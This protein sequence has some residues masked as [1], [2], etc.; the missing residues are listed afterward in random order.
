[1]PNGGL[2]LRG[3]I[4]HLMQCLGDVLTGQ[5]IDKK[6]RDTWLDL[7]SEPTGGR[8]HNDWSPFP[9]PQRDLQRDIG[10]GFVSGRDHHYFRPSPLAQ[11]TG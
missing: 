4:E 3:E 10:E 5:D 1:M 6:P 11:G 2:S 9:C 8:G 7:I